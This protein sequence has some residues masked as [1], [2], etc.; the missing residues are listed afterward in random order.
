VNSSVRPA[1]CDSRKAAEQ[2]HELLPQ[3]PGFHVSKLPSETLQELRSDLDP[4][5]QRHAQ[6]N[7]RRELQS[8]FLFACAYISAMDILFAC[9]ELN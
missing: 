2:E 4:D 9:I 5:T 6:E 7:K 1:A 3:P 8:K